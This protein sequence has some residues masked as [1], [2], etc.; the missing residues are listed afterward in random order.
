MIMSFGKKNGLPTRAQKVFDVSDL[1][2]DTG[3][4]EFLSKF[5]EIV[6]YGRQHPSESIAIGCE[7]GKHRSVVLANKV[8]TALRVGVFHRDKQLR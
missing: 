2:H 5:Q 8:A 1:S 7:K 4:P 3:S 6:D